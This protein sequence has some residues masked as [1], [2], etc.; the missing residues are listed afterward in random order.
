MA[1]TR[2]AEIACA[3]EPPKSE[4]LPLSGACR[5][6]SMSIVVD[7][8]APFG[9]SSATVSPSSTLTSTPRTACTRPADDRK[10]FSSARSSTPAT[11]PP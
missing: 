11:P 5:P 8:P 9:P 6:S 7:L 1:P 3:G 10:L 4:T 2:P